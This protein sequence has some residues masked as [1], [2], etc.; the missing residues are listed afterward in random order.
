MP[1]RT[2]VC[3]PTYNERENLS[4]LTKE[5]LATAPGA[6]ILV[7]DDGSPDGTGKIAE[8]LAREDSR[9][10]VLHRPRKNGLGRAYIDAF[11]W[12]LERGYDAVVQM[13]ADFSHNPCYLPRMLHLLTVSDAAVGSRRVPGGAVRGWPLYRRLLSGLGSAYSRTLLKSAVR[14]MTGGFNG[15]TREALEQIDYRSVRATGYGFQIEMKH[16]CAQKG[17]RVEEFP[18]VF[19]DRERGSSKMNLIIAA[20]A[21]IRVAQIALSRRTS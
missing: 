10:H 16:R 3:I 7:V 18:I 15:Y 20:E 13:D 11:D 12:A 17:L 21:L 2:L 14:D 19:T 6:D 5:I 9:L 8:E 1:M 4:K